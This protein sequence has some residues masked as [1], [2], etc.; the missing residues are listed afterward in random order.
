[1]VKDIL[2]NEPEIF[3]ISGLLSGRECLDV[4]ERSRSKLVDGTVYSRVDNRYTVSPGRRCRSCLVDQNF[5]REVSHKVSQVVSCKP[6]VV[7][8]AQ[9]VCYGV[10]DRFHNH[11]DFF[12]PRSP[13]LADEIRTNGQRVWSA[14]TYLNEEYSG[15]ETDFPMLPLRFKGRAGDTLFIRNTNAK[16]IPDRRTWHAGLPPLSGEKWVLIQ[17][18]REIFI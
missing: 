11:F 18:V 4:I 10:G 12:N 15:G 13:D 5:N 9:A 7:E 14:I 6:S 8:F 3:S 17:F 2:S 16:G 1:M